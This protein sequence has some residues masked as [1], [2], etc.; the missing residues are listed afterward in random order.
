VA[1]IPA[2]K[3]A[4]VRDRIDIERV[5]GRSVR[6][7]KKGRRAWGLCPFHKE[8]SPSFTVDVDKR[9]YH[10]FGCHLGGDV[11]DFV[12]R[13]EGMEF[14]DAVVMLAKEAN[15]EIVEREED[16]RER[17]ERL[18][19]E[20]LFEMNHV[21]TTFFEQALAENPRALAYLKEERHLRS[22]TL[23]RFSIGWAPEEWTALADHFAKKRM[24]SRL[25]LQLGL[26]GSRPKDGTPYDRLRGR[27][28]FPIALPFGDIAG[29]GARRADWVEGSDRSPKYLNSPESPIYDKS[30]ILYGL[31]FAKDEIRKTRRAVLVEG[32]VD[33]IGLHQGGVLEGVAACG[34]ALSPRHAAILARHA[35]EVVTM[36]DGDAAG[37]E[38]TRKA[39]EI[40]LHE[41]LKVRIAALPEGEDPDTFTQR[42]GAETVRRLVAEAPSAIDYFVERGRAAYKGGGIAGITQ[43]VES[44]KP[45]LLAVQDPL[46]RD[47][48]LDQTARALGIEIGLLRR[49]LGGRRGA[50]VRGQRTG[51]ANAAPA[52]FSVAAPEKAAPPEPVEMALLKMFLD[53]PGDVLGTLE[54]KDAVHAFQNPGIQAAMD[55]GIDAHRGGKPFDAARALEAA[56]ASGALGEEGLAALRR[57]LLEA[58]PAR[59]DVTVCVKRLLRTKIDITLRHLERQLAKES[60]AEAAA[61]LLKEVD[62]YNRLRAS[63]A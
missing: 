9:L 51:S 18:H 21:A 22:D 63:L 33:V 3:I 4:E 15:V 7:Q 44:V 45:L 31:R 42:R 57:T 36:Y 19:K 10:C 8:K 27:I 50:D 61:D 52:R 16:P 46:E 1:V 30:S 41:G 24:D 59:D 23:E 60:D 53:T 6:L 62:R 40:L 2:D 56:R 13:L 29:F 25:A 54:A 26:L 39:A 17:E 35:D 28:I 43:A 38:A 48:T 20:R 11:F 12:M 34:T 58:L 5:V 32:Y 14:R 47:L 55:A 37:Q 49:H